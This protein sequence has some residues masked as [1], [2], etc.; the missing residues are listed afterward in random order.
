MYNFKCPVCNSTNVNCFLEQS[1]VPVHQNYIFKEKESANNVKKGDLTLCLCE[2][3]NFIFNAKFDIALLEYE[4]LYDNTQDKSQIFIN[5]LGEEIDFLI[6]TLGVYEKRIIEV[7]CGKGNF[8]KRLVLESNSTGIGFDPSYVGET[9]QL[10]GKLKFIKNL[11]NKNCVNMP[12]DVVI[13]RHVI[14]H[15]PNPI[16]LLLNIKEALKNSLNAIVF[17]ETPLVDWILGNKIFYDFFY[18]HCSYFNDASIKEALNIAGFKVDAIYHKF[19][20]QYMWIVASI[21]N[22]RVTN[23]L[24]QIE[25]IKPLTVNYTYDMKNILSLWNDKV[26]EIAKIG[27][28]AIWGAAA[29]GTTFLNIIDP[30][31][32]YIDSVIDINVNK[33]GCFIA[34]TGHEI[35]DFKEI[36][37][38]NIKYLIVMNS[39]YI[40]EI[41][42]LLRKEEINNIIIIDGENGI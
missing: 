7:G 11:Y 16:E 2:E 23:N 10:D 9:I 38:R 3:C 17:F 39:N 42:G 32:K 29:K 5:Y 36:T 15:I 19:N 26:Q 41:K 22:E 13:C 40:N 33:Q 6:N 37:K 4:E 12:A 31:V 20:G 27:K 18:E 28:V 35:I 30:E 1:N 8:L 24:V 34:G 25:K 21:G 14:E